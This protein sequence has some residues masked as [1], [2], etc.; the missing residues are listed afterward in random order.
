MTP[1]TSVTKAPNWSRISAFSRSA[2]SP[3]R[4]PSPET[5]E[6]VRSSDTVHLQREDEVRASGLGPRG[7]AGDVL[8]RSAGAAALAGGGEAR[9]AA[10]RASGTHVA[11]P[12]VPWAGTAGP[13]HDTRSGQADRRVTPP[14]SRTQTGLQ[15]AG[16]PSAGIDE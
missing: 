15:N 1:R 13:Y 12:F 6:R 4:N 2:S 9:A 16:H 8:A 5:S 3:R 11:P 14:P 10:V 7:P